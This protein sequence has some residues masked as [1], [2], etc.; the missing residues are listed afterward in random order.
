MKLMRSLE[1]KSYEDQL[2]DL[3]CFSMEKRRL[4]GDLIT[5]YSDLK[6]D[7]G[8]VG[9]QPLLSSSSDTV[10]SI[11]LKLHQSRFRLWFRRFGACRSSG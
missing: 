4:I 3:G 5:L 8:G 9:G 11:G 10:R 1:H 7:C 2:R 6:G